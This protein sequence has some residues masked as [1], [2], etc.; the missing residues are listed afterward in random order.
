MKI[1]QNTLVNRLTIKMHLHIMPYTE[2][3]KEFFGGLPTAV[4]KSE[5]KSSALGVVFA[6]ALFL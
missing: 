6:G 3:I 1:F 5:K 2:S 4:G